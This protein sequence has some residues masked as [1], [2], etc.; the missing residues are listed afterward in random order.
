MTAD[1]CEAAAVGSADLIYQSA[2]AGDSCWA[3]NHHG[4]RREL[5]M[6]RWLG[7]PRPRHRIGS[8]MSTYWGIA[9]R[10]PLWIWGAVPGDSLLPCD[11]ADCPHSGSTVLPPRWR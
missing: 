11:S 7:G 10:A 1:A 5:P 8:P 4:H 6:G 9:L 3:R 2:A